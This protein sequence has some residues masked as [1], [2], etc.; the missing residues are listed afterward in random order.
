VEKNLL[1]TGMLVY[2][3]GGS[4]KSEGA[5]GEHKSQTNFFAMHYR[6]FL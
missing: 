5:L 4:Q 1:L 3:F 6:C 2:R